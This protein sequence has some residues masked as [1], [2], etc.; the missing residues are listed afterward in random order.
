MVSGTGLQAT[1]QIHAQGMP[2]LLPEEFIKSSPILKNIQA[3]KELQEI[4]MRGLFA[5]QDPRVVQRVIDDQ[6][7]LSSKDSAVGEIE[8]G[9][10]GMDYCIA[11]IKRL[12]L[13]ALLAEYKERIRRLGK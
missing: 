2:V 5:D 6:K 12:Q 8:V 4:R 7:K 13:D 9:Y 1:M 3:T 11:L 10:R